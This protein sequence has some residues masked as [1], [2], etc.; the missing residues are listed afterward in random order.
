MGNQSM[1]LVAY[2]MSPTGHHHGA[3]RHPANSARIFDLDHWAEVARTYERGCFDM[4]FMPDV[5]A[6]PDKI[7]SFASAV[8]GGSQA[9]VQLDP[10]VVLSAVAGKT[11]RIGLG[12]TR[13]T[14][15]YTAF[16]IARSFATLD[17][18]SGGRAAWN[19]V[20]STMDSEAK[21]FGLGSLPARDERYDKG[22]EVI[23]A[24]MAL[25]DSWQDGA[26]V[27][28]KA[29]GVFADPDKVGY[30]DYAGKWVRT[31]G[32]LTVP[33]SP[34]G[35]PVIMQA[36]SSPRGRAYAARWGEL[37]FALQHSLPDM[38]AFTSDIKD[39][40]AAASRSREDCR[41]LN[42]VQIVT[43]ETREI[44][45]AKRDYL[46][47]LVSP[48]IGITTM[49]YHVGVDL[50]AY[51]ADAPLAEVLVE[52]GSRGS[53]DVILRG[54][55]AEGLTLAEAARRFA[56]TELTPQLVGTGEEVADRLEEY[57][58]GGGCDGFVV[59]PGPEPGNAR[60]IVD[61][62][63]PELQRR[64]LLRSEYP[65]GTLRDVIAATA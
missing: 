50:T 25:W 11:S 41:V 49:S 9:A 6:I 55:E 62:V 1:S 44:A 29:A 53:L 59:T 14:T 12:V 4:V 22:D 63:V 37:V 3:W 61:Y 26:V 18:I 64:G 58:L 36:G 2:L 52:T 21:N 28:D 47:A 38:V 30:V 20:T 17:H 33:R 34:Q 48:E 7:G 27:F 24:C 23:A 13:S 31:R 40:A 16:E 65:P 8:R 35:R 60:D 43:G 19:V 46:N 42:A 51:P 54:S 57:F 32:P 5:L 15:F 10:M 39:R 56:T 45:A